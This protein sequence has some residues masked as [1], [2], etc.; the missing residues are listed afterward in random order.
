MAEN[1]STDEVVILGDESINSNV[2]CQTQSVQPKVAKERKKRSRAWDNFGTFAD[3]EGNKKAKC[4]HCGQ[5]YFADSVKNGTKAMLTHMLTCKKMPKVVD[6]S[7]TQIGFQ[8]VQGGNTC[9]VVVV[10]WKFEQEQCR[11]ALCRMVIVD[12]LPFKFVEKEGF[13]NFM[14]VAQHHF[15]IPSRTTV[16]RD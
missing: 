3:E 12:E 13:R 4:K 16:T 2:M 5:D 9:D 14:K 10:S 1:I 7:Q 8:S 6:K 15:K 11:R